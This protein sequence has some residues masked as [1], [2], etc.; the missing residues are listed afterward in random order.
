MSVENDQN[1]YSIADR[2]F[3]R[4]AYEYPLEWHRS[5]INMHNTNSTMMIEP[6]K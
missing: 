2:H 1:I 6:K 3:L 5:K 4:N